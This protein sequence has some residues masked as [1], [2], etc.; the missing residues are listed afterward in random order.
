MKKHNSQPNHQKSSTSDSN[1]V[2]E[3]VEHDHTYSP[4][5]TTK[6]DQFQK[7]L[8]EEKN[9]Q[10]QFQKENEQ[11]KAQL[12]K[13]EMKINKQEIELSQLLHQNVQ[14]NQNINMLTTKNQKLIINLAEV[15]DELANVKTIC[16]NE[17][18]FVHLVSTLKE[19]DSAENSDEEE[20]NN[21]SSTKL[22][23]SKKRDR[24]RRR[25]R[26][27][28]KRLAQLLSEKEQQLQH[29]RT[30]NASLAK[31][32]FYYKTKFDSLDILV[33]KYHVTL[34]DGEITQPAQIMIKKIA[35]TGEVLLIVET[36]SLGDAEGTDYIQNMSTIQLRIFNVEIE[37]DEE[38]ETNDVDVSASDTNLIHLPNSDTS[39]H[40][41]KLNIF[42]SEKKSEKK[43]MKKVKYQFELIFT[44]DGNKTLVFQ[45]KTLRKRN[46]YCIAIQ[47]M[48]ETTKKPDPYR[49]P[50]PHEI[51]DNFN[52]GKVEKS[53]T[54]SQKTFSPVRSTKS[55]HT[56]IF[57]SS[58]LPKSSITSSAN[59]NNHVGSF[60][61]SVSSIASWPSGIPRLSDNDPEEQTSLTN[62]NDLYADVS[63]QSL[64]Q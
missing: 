13:N 49:N 55:P 27:E 5:L 51:N 25:W 29:Q 3:K 57:K 18:S 26:K 22:K 9:T 28:L 15:R 54:N 1:S 10:Q 43:T 63:N 61:S 39:V 33:K 58:A 19:V 52:A 11:L 12:Q 21:D 53:Q 14:L 64:C 37:E 48:I 47:E 46:K 30:F 38:F 8:K 16:Q 60:G 23:Q 31:K 44:A 7:T 20:K 6:L 2:P 17:H 35:T 50:L 34:V 59:P 32:T 40:H 42:E 24:E 36:Q 56:E 4:D 41:G 62:E 45:C